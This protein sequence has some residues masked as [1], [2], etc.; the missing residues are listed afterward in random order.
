MDL[1]FI[2]KDSQGLWTKNEFEDKC[3]IGGGGRDI[4]EVLETLTTPAEHQD[5]SGKFPFAII[6]RVIF[7]PGIGVLLVL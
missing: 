3:H 4:G 5:N 7:K 1:L 6:A 2:E